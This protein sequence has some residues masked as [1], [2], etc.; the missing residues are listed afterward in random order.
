VR[1]FT[2][3]LS[4]TYRF[5]PWLALVASY[6]LFHQRSDSTLITPAGTPVANDVDQNRLSVGLTIGYPIRFD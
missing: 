4:A 2:L 1:S 6:I 5:T 3:P